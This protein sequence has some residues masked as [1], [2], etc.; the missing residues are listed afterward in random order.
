M[1]KPKVIDYNYEVPDPEKMPKPAIKTIEPG[2]RQEYPNIAA[3]LENKRNE[4]LKTDPR[5]LQFEEATN[6]D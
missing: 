2:D 1:I 4:R 3:M 6:L 5:Y